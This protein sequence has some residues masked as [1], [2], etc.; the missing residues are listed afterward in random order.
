MRIR[1]EIDSSEKRLDQLVIDYKKAP[2]LTTEEN[3]QLIEH[4]REQLGSD[5]LF[6]RWLQKPHEDLSNPQDPDS[7][8]ARAHDGDAL[9]L[10]DRIRYADW[11]YGNGDWR[12][13]GMILEHTGKRASDPRFA[14]GH[15]HGF[16]L[17][18]RIN[19]R[20]L[21][22]LKTDPSTCTRLGV[23]TINSPAILGMQYISIKA[24]RIRARKTKKML[25]VQLD[26]E[27]NAS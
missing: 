6:V 23:F 25:I 2:I 7:R 20:A 3:E 13:L 1:I 14:L 4:I 21:H 10:N 26:Q 15:F 9:W 19:N 24:R 16:Q 12:Q 18:L 5:Q 22:P 11:K 17:A 27:M 8:E